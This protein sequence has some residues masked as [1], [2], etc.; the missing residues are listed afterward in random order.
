MGFQSTRP[1]GARPLRRL[2]TAE[3]ELFQS[4]RPRGARHQL[5]S[6]QRRP[7]GVSI[8]APAR[9][10]TAP[11]IPSRSGQGRFNPR[12]REG[13]DPGTF[14]MDIGIEVSIHA[15]ARGATCCIPAFRPWP[16]VSIHAPARG[17]THYFQTSIA[18]S[19]V[20]IHAP[21]RGAT[22]IEETVRNLV[23]VSIHAPARGATTILSVATA[24]VCLFQSTRPR[25]ARP[26]RPA[27]PH[28]CGLFQSTRPRGARH[29]RRH[30]SG[31]NPAV[32]IHAPA[33]G[34]TCGK[35]HNTCENRG[36]NPRAREGRDD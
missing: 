22:S 34:A 18:D 20:S 6:G 16:R 8:H 26:Y 5:V 3:F 27:A 24:P 32:S 17:A 12:A 10:A 13:R 25:G 11:S 9:G 1:R 23:A 28:P 31:R 14:E 29:S 21:A 36:F 33:R 2:W 30:Q 35:H 4:T 19:R 7:H 15:P